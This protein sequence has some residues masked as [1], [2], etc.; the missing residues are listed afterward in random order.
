MNDVDQ[1]NFEYAQ[2]EINKMKEEVHKLKNSPGAQAE[3]VVMLINW[4]LETLQNKQGSIKIYATRL[5]VRL[6]DEE[7]KR[8]LGVK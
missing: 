8:L 6:R 7:I 5:L 4:V 3:E 1:A 2:D